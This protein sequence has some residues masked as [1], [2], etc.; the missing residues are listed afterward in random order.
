MEKKEIEMGKGGSPSSYQS[1]SDS[2]QLSFHMN[3]QESVGWIA[4][5]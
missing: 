1:S 5:S 2:F 3:D 4:P